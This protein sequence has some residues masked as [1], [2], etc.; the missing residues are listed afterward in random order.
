MHFFD[1]IDNLGHL[2]SG[3]ADAAHL[4]GLA[5]ADALANAVA[6]GAVSPHD[7]LSLHGMTL[8]EAIVDSQGCRPICATETLENMFQLLIGDVRGAWNNLSDHIQQVAKAY[9]WGHVQ[10]GGVVLYPEHYGDVMNALGAP[11]SWHEF[12]TDL[13]AGTLDAGRPIAAFVDAAHLGYPNAGA[14]AI[15]LTGTVRDAV[16]RIAGFSGLDSNFPGREQTWSLDQ[17]LGGMRSLA[18]STG[19]WWSGRVFVPD[20]AAGLWPVRAC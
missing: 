17:I 10:D 3:G 19:A 15:T 16:G 1:W 2:L 14:H 7:L 4:D 8:S 20:V 12:R 5:D 11:C 18:T 13:V 9:D 6:S